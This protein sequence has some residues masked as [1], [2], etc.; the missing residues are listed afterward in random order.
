[1]SENTAPTGI[2][3]GPE[4]DSLFHCYSDPKIRDIRC[5]CRIRRTRITK[6]GIVT[7]VHYHISSRRLRG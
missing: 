5:L 3:D 1:M 7:T 6:D 4:P 2:G